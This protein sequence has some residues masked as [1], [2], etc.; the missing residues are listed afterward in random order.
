MA[1]LILDAS[2]GS[3]KLCVLLDDGITKQVIRDGIEI[4]E[5]KDPQTVLSLLSVRI[6]DNCF[7]MRVGC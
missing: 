5:L 6:L 7:P 1:D 4:A 3:Y 2:T